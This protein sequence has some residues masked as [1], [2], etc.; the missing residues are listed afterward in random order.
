MKDYYMSS[1]AEIFDEFSNSKL[2]LGSIRN[3]FQEFVENYFIS[4]SSFMSNNFGF[5]KLFGIKDLG[6]LSDPFDA[7]RLRSEQKIQIYNQEDLLVINPYGLVVESNESKELESS[8][9]LS[10]SFKLESKNLL[11]EVGIYSQNKSELFKFSPY[12]QV[13][14]NGQKVTYKLKS[15]VTSKGNLD[16]NL[17]EKSYLGYY[18]QYEIAKPLGARNAWGAGFLFG[19]RPEMKKIEEFLLANEQDALEEETSGTIPNVQSLSFSKNKE[20]LVKKLIEEY[21]T[22]NKLNPNEYD[23]IDTLVKEH[24][25]AFTEE[26]Q[27]ED[28]LE[29]SLKKNLP[30]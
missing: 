16:I 30:F 14:L 25:E 19:A 8:P 13:E 15:L 24:S 11:K 17:N 7:N 26:N 18:A 2:S 23:S 10:E 6:N 20:S 4:S 12:Y 28:Y 9:K 5:K 21:M 3:Y 29:C 1:T 27:F 22:K